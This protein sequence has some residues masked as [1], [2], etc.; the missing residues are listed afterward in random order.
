MEEIN[1]I[2]SNFSQTAQNNLSFHEGK[3]RER[4]KKA[5]ETSKRLFP[6]KTF[7]CVMS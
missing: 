2:F 3:W 6:C 4:E 1:K 5:K 7:K